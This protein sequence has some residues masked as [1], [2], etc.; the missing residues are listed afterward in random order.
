VA[1]Q[2]EAPAVN[3]T[4][5]I[6]YYSW[7]GKELLGG[8]EEGKHV[9]VALPAERTVRALLSE[10]AADSEPF[11]RLVYD[12]DE[13]RLKEYATLIVNGRTVELAGGLDAELKPNDQLLLLPGFSGG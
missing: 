2:Q 8:G 12:P 7:L 13:R 10:L 1:G 3:G 11:R 5:E 4:V 6:E 9:V